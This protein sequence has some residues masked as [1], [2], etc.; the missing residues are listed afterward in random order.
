MA[1]KYKS[2]GR[3]FRRD[4]ETKKKE[5]TDKGETIKPEKKKVY[6]KILKKKAPK[7]ADI[8]KTMKPRT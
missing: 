8:Y 7:A 2:W 5:M 3:Q 6:K 4:P 1:D